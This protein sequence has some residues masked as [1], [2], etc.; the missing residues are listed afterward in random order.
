M[1]I[2]KEINEPLSHIDGK[3]ARLE[4]A[5]TKCNLE[6]RKPM[7]PDRHTTIEIDAFSR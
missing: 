3:I 5:K 2:R 6:V 7:P 4:E 1:T